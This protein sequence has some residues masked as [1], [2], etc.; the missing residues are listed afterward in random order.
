MPGLGSP[1]PMLPL[2]E[3]ARAK[4]NLSLH[5][6]GRRA[7]GYHE[8]ESLVVFAA[9]ADD[10][11][12]EPGD[13]FTLVVEGE[14]ADA[15]GP[16][17]DNLVARA[18][19]ALAER[20]PELRTGRF[21]LV[22][23]LPVAAGLGGGSAD[24]A[25]ALRLLAKLNGLGLG[26]ERVLSAARAVG[27]D[28]TV[29]LHSRPALMRGIGHD[30]EVL[31]A[32]P[33]FDAVL[34]NP[35]VAVLTRPVFEALALRLGEL[36]RTR[37]HPP[38]KTDADPLATLAAARNDLSGPARRIAP[39]I[40]DVEAALADKGAL[41]VRM[42]GSGATV[43]GLFADR[44]DAARAATTV[45]AAHPDWWVRTTELGESGG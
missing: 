22:K 38:I 14:T 45:A 21:R 25:A 43:F 4:V 32:W 26:D 40:A 17:E 31:D 12:L 44:E 6:L 13:R 35:R 34:V 36:D 42:S 9:V 5:V 15:A 11:R 1:L 3:I 20:V 19:R 29:C 8:L 18:V 30:V 28:C 24:A 16:V 7:D 2:A 39:V 37:A 10:L 41:L 33:A 27:A 23:R